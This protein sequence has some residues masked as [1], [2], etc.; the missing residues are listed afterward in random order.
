MLHCAVW[1]SSPHSLGASAAAHE[2]VREGGGEE[3]DKDGDDE[4][5][6]RERERKETTQGR[7]STLTSA[8]LAM[9]SWRMVVSLC[10][11]AQWIGLC[12]FCNPT[13]FNPNPAPD[14]VPEEHSRPSFPDSATRKSP[15]KHIKRKSRR[16]QI[17]ASRPRGRS[18]LA[19][20]LV[21]RVRVSSLVEEDPNSLHLLLV[22]SEMQRSVSSLGASD[23]TAMNIKRRSARRSVRSLHSCGNAERSVWR[24]RSCKN[25]RGTRR[26]HRC[27]SYTA[28]CCPPFSSRCDR[29]SFPPVEGIVR[30]HTG[31][32]LAASRRDLPPYQGFS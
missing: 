15:L 4:E 11:A 13:H 6:E 29:R 16:A 17:I 22:D 7:E 24:P 8:P 18:A 19:A 5:R 2:K 25:V 32:L 30:E 23:V 20:D 12:P 9:R 3:E 21:A 1:S 26:G 27:Q 31:D 28:S 10:M 14:C